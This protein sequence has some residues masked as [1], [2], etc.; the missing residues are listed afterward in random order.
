MASAS[1]GA[2]LSRMKYQYLFCP[3]CGLRRF[4]HGFRCTVCQSLLR[5]PRATRPVSP[6]LPFSSEPLLR[7][8]QARPAEVASPTRAA[9]AA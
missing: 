2:K 1:A 8:W 6:S 3:T 7:S 9:V 5:R 4:G